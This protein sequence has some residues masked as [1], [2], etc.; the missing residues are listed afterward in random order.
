V[1]YAVA[2]TAESQGFC[3]TLPAA[4]VLNAY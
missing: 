2:K 1:S 4:K 3:P